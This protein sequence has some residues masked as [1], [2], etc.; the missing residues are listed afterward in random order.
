MLISYIIIV[1]INRKRRRKLNLKGWEL[2]SKR[3]RRVYLIHLIFGGIILF[4][5]MNK[6]FIKF[7]IPSSL[8]LYGISSIIVNTYTLGS[9]KILGIL[10]LINGILSILF[11]NLLFILWGLAFGGYHI[12]YGILHYKKVNSNF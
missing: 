9:T 4:I 3:I 8:L 10:F 6:G 2:K 12:I 11:P 5:L 1:L 7:I